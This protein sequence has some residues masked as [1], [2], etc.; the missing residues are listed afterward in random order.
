M[1]YSSFP[2]AQYQARR[3]EIDAAMSRVVN[4]P[5]YILGHEVVAFEREFAAYVG[6]DYG[7]GVA[8]GTDALLLTL[9]AMGIGRG[10]EVITVS[11]TAV[12]TAAAIGLAGA[13]PVFVDI[14]PRYFTLDVTGLEAAITPK[15]K[16]IIPVHLY[17]QPADM[18]AIVAVARRHNMKLIEDCA[19]ATGAAYRGRLAG[20]IGDA[21][22][23]SF[24]P[25]K[26]LGGIGDGGMV[27]TNDPQLAESLQMLRQY[28]WR[29]DRNSHV[30]GTNSRL[31][32]I[33]AAILR[34]KLPYLDADNARRR[35]I[36][37]AYDRALAGSNLAVPARRDEASHIF[38]LYVVRTQERAAVQERLKRAGVAAGIHYP[39]PVHR[40]PAFAAFAP[41][42]GLPETE[43]AAT[44]VL[45]L[46]MYPEL[47]EAMIG[48]VVQ[49]L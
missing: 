17:G 4:G 19:Q 21:G 16:A 7:I 24:Y 34:V 36:A 45:S 40:Q 41:S 6:V 35:A 29:D 9:R 18:D 11:H 22:C 10:D 20:S 43:R 30:L 14:D 47:D 12:A 13:T 1:I 5:S 46:P 32:E 26:N 25:T 48:Q 33:Q 2:Q 23:F 3:A 27:V 42:G 39:V 31:D 28:G 44:E 8:S 49:R 15:T 38:H 37:D